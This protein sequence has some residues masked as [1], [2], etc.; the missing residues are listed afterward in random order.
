ME[1]NKYQIFLKV[2]ECRSFSKAAA[3]LGYTQPAVSHSIAVLEKEFGFKLLNRKEGKVSL[4]RAGIDIV[5][6]VRNVVNAQ[7]M[8]DLSLQSYKGIESGTLC[9][10]TINSIAV[11]FF[12]RLLK[13]FHERY[14]AIHVVV[15]DGNYEEIEE[16]LADGRVDFGFTSVSSTTPFEYKTLLRDRLL[17]VLP[18][19]HVLCKK[20]TISLKDLEKA[21]FIMPGEGPDHQVGELIRKY[22]LKFLSTYAISDDMLSLKM[23]SNGLGVSILPEMDFRNYIEFPIVA[24]ELVEKPYRDVGIIY[25]HWD[26]VSPLSRIFINVTMDYFNN[27]NKRKSSD[28]V[29]RFTDL[30]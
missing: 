5:P 18:P 3:E 29:V 21:D 4:T 27:L 25:S 8:L 24:R 14:P 22:N 1:T 17:A 10:A 15:I 9:I 7:E 28:H 12:P 2:I 6:H 30:I 13:C 16:M 20:E 11:Q 26:H 19:D 23:I